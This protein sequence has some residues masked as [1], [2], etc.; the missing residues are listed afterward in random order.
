M[1]IADTGIHIA[2]LPGLY[3]HNS[4]AIINVLHSTRLQ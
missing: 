2:A 4:D 1:E 3:T